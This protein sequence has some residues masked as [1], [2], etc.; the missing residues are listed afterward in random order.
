[1]AVVPDRPRKLP[2]PPPGSPERR[3]D[4]RFEIYAQIELRHGD[5]VE[6]L[7]VIDISAGGARLGLAPGQSVDVELHEKVA[8]FL[9]LDEHDFTSQAEVVRIG[10]GAIGLMWSSDD[11]AVTTALTALLHHIRS[12]SE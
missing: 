11:P 12:L 10:E 7:P 8:V 3:K 6:L 1:M 2:P 5:H 4:P 9:H